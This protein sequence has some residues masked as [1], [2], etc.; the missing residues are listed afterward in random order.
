MPGGGGGGAMDMGGGDLGDL[1][2]PGAEEEGAINGVEGEM[3]MDAAANDMGVTEQP[4]EMP[5]ENK[6]SK[7]PLLLES[8]RLKEKEISY[9]RADIY[10]KALMINE[11]FNA[12]LDSLNKFTEN[13]NNTNDE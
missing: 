13:S 9:N 10:D 2:S 4:N 7:L 5:N 6:T 11:E 3:P 8:K 1:G 12:M